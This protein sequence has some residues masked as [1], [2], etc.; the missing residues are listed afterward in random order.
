MG[1]SDIIGFIISITSLINLPR[2]KFFNLSI[3]FVLL[4]S[5]IIFI[6]DYLNLE[7]Y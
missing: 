6:I 4:L 3:I 5:S 7:K 1:I 2:K